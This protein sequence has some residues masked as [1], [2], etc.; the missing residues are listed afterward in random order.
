MYE[1]SYN[2]TVVVCCIFI[3]DGVI[4]RVFYI[5]KKHNMDGQTGLSNITIITGYL[6]QT[7]GCNLFPVRCV[8]NLKFNF[9]VLDKIYVWSFKQIDDCIYGPV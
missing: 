2:T 3:S 1:Q 7:V 9:H 6:L 5:Y 8:A 4:S